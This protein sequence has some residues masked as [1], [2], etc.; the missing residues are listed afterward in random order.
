MPTAEVAASSGTSVPCI[1]SQESAGH[2]VVYV[3]TDQMVGDRRSP[4]RQYWRSSPSTSSAFHR[5]PVPPT[6]SVHRDGSFFLCI[7]TGAS[8]FWDFGSLYQTLRRHSSQLL[9]QRHFFAVRTLRRLWCRLLRQ[10]LSDSI[11]TLRRP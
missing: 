10:R 9:R 4:G 8:V 7:V 2:M 3:V 1:R 11:S 6:G 5:F